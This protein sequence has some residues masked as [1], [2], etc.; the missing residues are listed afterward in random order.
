MI[1]IYYVYSKYL[2]SSHIAERVNCVINLVYV[3]IMFEYK[4]IEHNIVLFRH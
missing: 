2:K 4:S 3:Q 1:R